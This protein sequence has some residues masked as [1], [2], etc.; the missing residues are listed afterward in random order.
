MLTRKRAI[1]HA[2]QRGKYLL[3]QRILADAVH[4]ADHQHG[5]AHA[6]I[7]TCDQRGAPALNL[8]PLCLIRNE[9][10]EKFLPWRNIA[11]RWLDIGWAE[12]INRIAIAAIGDD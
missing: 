1:V 10:G 2:N 8:K 12:Y 6:Y 3:S 5:N 9:V 7:W 4:L 11:D